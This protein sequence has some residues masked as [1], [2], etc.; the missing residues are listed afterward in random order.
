M[1][2]V[3][4][5][6]IDA[7]GRL[8]F[9]LGCNGVFILGEKYWHHPENVTPVTKEKLA[10]VDPEGYVWYIKNGYIEDHNHRK[11]YFN[12]VSLEDYEIYVI[13]ED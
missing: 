1:L 6:F 13:E 8:D 2:N 12:E 7:N 5:P 11:R 10:L 9:K 4:D 3:G